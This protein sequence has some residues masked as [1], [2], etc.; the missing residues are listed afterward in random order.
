MQ[1]YVNKLQSEALKRVFRN[2][3]IILF[4]E[5]WL[6][7]DANIQVNSFKHFQLN[8]TLRKRRR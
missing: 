8:R 4:T 6:S 5:T 2:N 3:G 1:K 7:E